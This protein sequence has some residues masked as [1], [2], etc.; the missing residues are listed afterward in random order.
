MIKE[1][2]DKETQQ[3]VIEHS[4]DYIIEKLQQENKQLN[5]ILNELEL[6]KD[7]HTKSIKTIL[8]NGEEIILYSPKYIE[9]LQ[10][11][12]KQLTSILIELK[13]WLKEKKTF[14]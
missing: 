13:Q 5:I 12:N 6:L 7:E 3:T 10:Q 14:L 8:K 1:V 11:E 2:T 9:K 4:K